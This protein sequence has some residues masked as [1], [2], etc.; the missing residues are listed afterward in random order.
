MCRPATHDNDV[1]DDELTDQPRINELHDG[2]DDPG[3]RL[4]I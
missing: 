3:L 4:M 1:I 2:R